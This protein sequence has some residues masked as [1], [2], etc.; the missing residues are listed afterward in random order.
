MPDQKEL[1]KYWT[2]GPAG[3]LPKANQVIAAVNELRQRPA[4]PAQKFGTRPRGGGGG[5]QFFPAIITGSA[6]FGERRKY[7][8]SEAE[9]TG[10]TWQ[11]KSGGRSGT[12]S[13]DY[14]LNK[15]E[16]FHTSQYKYGV[17]KDGDAY[18]AGFD[19]RP[20][21]GAGTTDTHKINVLVD[22]EEVTNIE[23]ATRY[24]FS[25]PGSH[26]GDCL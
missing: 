4:P 10:D 26:D 17:D 14:A 8:W 15:L 6:A 19:D 7:A 11:V 2:K 25:A 21:G 18:P 22:M 16:A 23:G 3:F 12:T 5:S 20:V 13:T 9:A 24:W 1:L